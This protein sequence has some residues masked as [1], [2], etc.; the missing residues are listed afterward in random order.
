[1]PDSLPALEAGRAR[2]FPEQRKTGDLDLE[3]V[4]L[5]LRT[6]IHAAGVTG[7][8][9]LLRQPG[10]VPTGVPCACGGHARY[11]DV[12]LRPILTLLGPAKTLRAYQVFPLSPRAVPHRHRP[13]H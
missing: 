4:E 7:L 12:R 1:M 13:R 5:A 10:P 3:A 2:I 6:A 8:T 11:K 9:E